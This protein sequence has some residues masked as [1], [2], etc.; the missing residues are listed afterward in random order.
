MG[1]RSQFVLGMTTGWGLYSDVHWLP[2]LRRQ[3]QRYVPRAGDV[4]GNGCVDDT[5]LLTVS[6]AFGSDNPDADANG[7]G[8][9]DD[10]DLLTVLFNFG[11][12]C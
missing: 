1:T 11:N 7:D 8:L 3:A 12:G 10:A 6:F 4:D 2:S 5:D 9:V